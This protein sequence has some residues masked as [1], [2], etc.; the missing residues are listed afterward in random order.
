M[1]RVDA[2]RIPGL[3]LL[4]HSEDH[5]PPHL[6]VRRPWEWEVRI[7]LL[8]LTYEVIWSGKKNAPSIRQMNEVIVQARKDSPTW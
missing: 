3:E 7:N 6:H 2:L 5:H 4:F 8:S 1:P